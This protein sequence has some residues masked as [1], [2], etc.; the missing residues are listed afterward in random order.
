MILFENVTKAYH[1][2]AS[3]PVALN[4][5]SFKI[6]PNEF[7]FLVGASGSGKSTLL[8]I[9]LADEKIT[10]GTVHVLGRNVSKLS[11]RKIP[12]YRRKIGSVFQDFKLL[13]NKNVFDNVAFAMQILGAHKRTIKSVV[14]DVLK[15]V[16]LQ[17]MEKRMP[18]ELSGG[19]QQRVAIAR[20]VVNKPPILLADEPTGNLDPNT[21][22]EIMDALDRVNE[23]GA[24]V[25]MATHDT[26]LVDK[27]KRRVIEL[28]KGKIIRDEQ[29]GSYTKT[30]PVIN[31]Q[32]GS[33][34]L[35]EVE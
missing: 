17:N 26:N 15:I 12:F 32:T 6:L 22:D 18:Y 13:D 5:V 19:E 1:K 3:V 8:N 21:S 14:P 2:S 29:K 28:D 27:K 33:E 34:Q 31:E 35:S 16:G 24:T 11:N 9:V 23:Y 30:M 10:K 20:A 7:V 25:L 4:N